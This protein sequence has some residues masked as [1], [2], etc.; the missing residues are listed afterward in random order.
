MKFSPWFKIETPPV[1]SGYYDLLDGIGGSLRRLWYDVE[2]EEWRRHKDTKS[3]VFIAC[4]RDRWR[5]MS[6]G[7]KK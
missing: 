3:D 1:R 5:G 6:S 2:H 4:S 7:G